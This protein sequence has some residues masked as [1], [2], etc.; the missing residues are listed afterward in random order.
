MGAVTLRVERAVHPP[1]AAVRVFLVAQA[2]GCAAWWV[3]VYASPTVRTLTLGTWDPDRLVVPDLVLFGAASLVAGISG[4]WIAG[5]VTA[6][7]SSVVTAV[8]FAHALD[9]RVGGWGVVAM[10]LATVS[11]IAA[12]MTLRDGRVPTDWF[13]RGPFRFREA[14]KHGPAG[15]LVHSITQLVIFWV[16]LLGLLPTITARIEHHLRIDASWLDHGRGVVVGVALFGVASCLG[17]WACVTM[18]LIGH[19]TPLPAAT[20]Q[21]LVVAGPYRLVRNPMAVAGVG[22]TVGVGVALGSWVVIVAAFAGAVIWDA[23]IRPA[24]EADLVARFGSS[25]DDYRREVRCWLPW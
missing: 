24:E 12:T 15:H 17:L 9:E 20:A 22:Q 21:D 6:G 16:L 13:F 8:L 18:A 23:V 3:A 4:W 5:A 10:S 2:V 1:M 19:G 7:W 14:R 11:T 25:Y